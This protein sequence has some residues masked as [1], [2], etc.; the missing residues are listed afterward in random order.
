MDGFTPQD[1]E[2]LKGVEVKQDDLIKVVEE[3]ILQAKGEVGFPRCA[4]RS[5]KWDQMEKFRE[6]MENLIDGFIRWS[7]RIGVGGVVVAAIVFAV[8]KIDAIMSMME[9]LP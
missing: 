5:V 7:T 2:R 6:R 3:F 9:R 1:R 8:K 4:A